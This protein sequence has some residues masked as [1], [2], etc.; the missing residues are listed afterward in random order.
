MRIEAMNFDRWLRYN[1]RPDDYVVMKIDIEGAEIP[2]LNRLIETKGVQLIDEM[3]YECHYHELTWQNPEVPV[4]M[5][6][7]QCEQMVEQGVKFWFWARREVNS[8]IKLENLRTHETD[9]WWIKYGIEPNDCMSLE[10][11]FEP[12][13]EFEDLRVLGM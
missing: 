13:P 4:Q 11:K 12:L 5:C 7:R 10:H 9:S 8:A 1:L 3:L 2:V 6:R